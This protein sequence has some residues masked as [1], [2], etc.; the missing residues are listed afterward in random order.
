MCL[1]SQKRGKSALQQAATGNHM[2]VV[3]LLLKNGAPVYGG[4]CLSAATKAGN[5]DMVKLLLKSRLPSELS[6]TSEGSPTHCHLNFALM[7][8][9]AIGHIEIGRVL[10]EALARGGAF[11]LTKALETNTMALQPCTFKRV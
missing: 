5:V 4:Y 6:D 1:Q 11:V 9:A 3:E 7:E 8:A 2:D 10:L